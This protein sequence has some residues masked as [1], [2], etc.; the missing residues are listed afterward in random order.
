MES[1]STISNKYLFI[2]ESKSTDTQTAESKY[3]QDK[4]SE[5]VSN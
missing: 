5:M 3:V 1:N 4:N 2:S